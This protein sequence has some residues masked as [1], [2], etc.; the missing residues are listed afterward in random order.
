[1]CFEFS[2]YTYQFLIYLHCMGFGNKRKVITFFKSRGSD[3]MLS[4]KDNN[5]VK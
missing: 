1:M 5:T 2:E 3:I 4:T